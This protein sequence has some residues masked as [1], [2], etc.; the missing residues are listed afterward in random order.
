MDKCQSKEGAQK[1]L[2]DI[3]KFLESSSA[4]L[5]YDPQA[6]HYDFESVLTSELKVSNP[7]GSLWHSIKQVSGIVSFIVLCLGSKCK[8]V[9]VIWS[10]ESLSLS[11]VP[12][13]V[14]A[15]QAWKRPKHVW[16]PSVLL[17]E[18]AG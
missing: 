8:I 13:T 1:A 15:G 9:V 17:Q 6:L 11:A 4:Y 10:Q 3:E 5:N 2:Q 7:S 14:S 18:A 12:D 16:E